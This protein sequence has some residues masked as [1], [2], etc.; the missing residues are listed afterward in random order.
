MIQITQSVIEKEVDQDIIVL[1]NF[2]I[3]NFQYFSLHPEHRKN[4][5]MLLTMVYDHY[6][7]PL[8]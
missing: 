6:L 1:L 8:I 2:P 5:D 4:I 7:G 3:V